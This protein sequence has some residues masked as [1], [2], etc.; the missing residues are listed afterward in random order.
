MVVPFSVSDVAEVAQ[1]PV[2]PLGQ[3]YLVWVAYVCH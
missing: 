2:R 1:A 3:W